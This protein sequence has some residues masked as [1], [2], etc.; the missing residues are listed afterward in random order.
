MPLGLKARGLLWMG[1]PEGGLQVAPLIH[2]CPHVC[3]AYACVR[4][5]L[6]MQVCILFMRAC[7]CVRVRLLMERDDLGEPKLHLAKSTTRWWCAVYCRFSSRQLRVCKCVSQGC[8]SPCSVW[9]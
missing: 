1:V 8:A 3:V 6:G 7:V 5:H 4:M 2:T 9:Y